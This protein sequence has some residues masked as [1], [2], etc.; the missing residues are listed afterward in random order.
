MGWRDLRVVFQRL[1]QK[2]APLAPTPNR[3]REGND[4]HWA[5]AGGRVS[6]GIQESSVIGALWMGLGQPM[7]FDGTCET[8]QA[9]AAKIHRGE[10]R[11]SHYLDDPDY[12]PHAGRLP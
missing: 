4:L 7:D 5:L 1:T 6:Q 2:L 11:V 8:D 10:G 12:R 9:L 3:L